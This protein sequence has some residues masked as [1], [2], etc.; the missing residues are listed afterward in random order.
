MSLRRRDFLRLSSSAALS[1]LAIRHA[2][3]CAEEDMAALLADTGPTLAG[4]LPASLMGA[5]GNELDVDLQVLSGKLP[6]EIA[7]HVFVVGAVPF[8]DGSPLFNGD[9]MVYRLDLGDGATGAKLKTRVM[10][11]PCYYADIATRGNA[12]HEF[13]NL[14]MIRMSGSFGARNELNTAF[15]PFDN[16]LLVT[17]DGGRP[18]EINPETLELITAVG[19]NTE[20]RAALPPSMANGPFP[21]QMST[22]HPIWDEYTREIF[23][24][25]YGMVLGEEIPGWLRL[26]RWD[27]QTDVEGWDVQLEDG[28]PVQILQSTHQLAITRDWLVIFDTSFLVEGEQIFDPSIIHAQKPQTACYLI[29]RSDLSQGGGTVTARLLVIDR[30]CVHMTADYENPNGQIT[31]HIAHNCATDAS[32]WL[33]EDDILADGTPVRADLVGLNPAATDVNQIGKH[34]LDAESGRVVE[35]NYFDDNDHTWQVAFFTHRGMT[36][37]GRHETMFWN[38]LGFTDETLTQRML[39]LYTDYPHRQIPVSS[40]VAK[41]ATLFRFNVTGSEIVDSYTF[42]SGRFASSPQFVPRSGSM[43]PH[44]GWLVCTV[45]SDDTSTPSSSGDEFWVFDARNLQQGPVTR[46][47]HTAL[48]MGFTLHTT[49]MPSFGPRNSNYRIDVEADHAPLIEHASDF[50]KQVMRDQVFPHFRV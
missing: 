10:K 50:V 44:N 41:P 35:S 15:M 46:L 2:A 18:W 11:T 38:S 6:R 4:R 47:G 48:N 7:G 39:D 34:V 19:T 23:T 14:G 32:E 37:P 1:W 16:R 27:G 42:P 9:G 36:A 33:R 29:R 8:R 40:L 20:W 31:L 26:L 25:N 30:E 17:F 5:T 49:F 43:E 45:I 12:S 24:V 22:A 13:V 28:S 21:P 3:G